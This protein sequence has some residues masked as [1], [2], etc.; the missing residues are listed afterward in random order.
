MVYAIT[1]K[2]QSWYGE[3]IGILILDAAYPC[4]PGNVG[5]A[6]SYPF[7]VRYHEVEGA[8]IDRLLNQCDP[9]LAGPFIAGALELQ[10]RGVKAVTGACGFMAI[11][12]PQVAA[13]LDIPVFLSPLL[14]IPFIAQ[15][16]GRPVGIITANAARLTPAHFAACGVDAGIPLRIAGMEGCA[17]FRSA[18]LEE[19]GTLNSGAIEA[20]VCAVA[21]RLVA[22]HP[23]VGAILLECSDLPPYAQAVQQATGRP[24]FDF[25]TM[26]TQVERA[27]VARRYQGAM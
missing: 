7:P 19:K 24:V 13:A 5:N 27:V 12:Q 22:D 1:R 26:I 3:S 23:Q 6:T 4:V 16:T 14:Q 11:F 25:N 10:A 17:E 20:E 2:S 15:I 18:I 21:R 9:T 8:S